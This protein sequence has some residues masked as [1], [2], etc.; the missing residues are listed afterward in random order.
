[1]EEETLIFGGEYWSELERLRVVARRLYGVRPWRPRKVGSGVEIS[2]RRPYE[3]GDEPRYIDWRYYG[4]TR[5]LVTRLYEAERDIGYLILLD[6]SVSMETKWKEALRVCHA[7]LY[8]ATSAGDRGIFFVAREGRADVVCGCRTEASARAAT[9]SI[10]SL[11]PSKKSKLSLALSS[12][13]ASSSNIHIV[14]IVSDM[15]EERGDEVLHMLSL[16]RVRRVVV[17]LHGRLDR[18]DVG[19]G[20]LR[21][22][23]S[24]DKGVVELVVDEMVLKEFKKEYDGWRIWMEEAA[25]DFGCEINFCKVE[26]GFG[27]AVERLFAAGLLLP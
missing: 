18:G 26:D 25:R 22:V 8:L 17:V 24:E 23:D 1:M 3:V 6:G 21:L 27:A 16:A 10:A 15:W 7:C 19:K 12:A 2:D 13:I 20:E 11:T 9:A 4:R 5:R 14:L